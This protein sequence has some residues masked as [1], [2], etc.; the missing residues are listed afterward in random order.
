MHEQDDALLDEGNL[1]EKEGRILDAA[2][3]IFALKG[4]S[5]TTTNEIAKEAGIAEGTIFRYFKTKKHLLHGLLKQLVHIMADRIAI[6]PIEK[7]LSQTQGKAIKDILKEVMI[8][9]MALVEKHFPLAKVVLSEAML[10]QDIRDIIL[11]KITDRVMPLMGDFIDRMVLEGKIRPMKSHIALRCFVGN[12]LLLV[13]Q[14]QLLKDKFPIEDIEQE[15]D[16]TIDLMLYGFA[17]R[18]KG[19][20]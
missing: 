14:R 10:H 8:D 9:R 19:G 7:I 15:I 6:P 4:F 12:T 3:K 13:V 5:A 2:C 20:I 18:E 16:E 1:N 17:N 11:G